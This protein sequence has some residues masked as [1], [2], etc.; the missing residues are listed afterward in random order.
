MNGLIKYETVIYIRLTGKD[1]PLLKTLRK[2][3]RNH[4]KGDCGQMAIEYIRVLEEP[5]HI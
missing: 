3:N 5:R 1:K 4:E 2:L